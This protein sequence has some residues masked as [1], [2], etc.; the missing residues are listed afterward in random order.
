MPS[1]RL[2]VRRIAWT[3]CYGLLRQALGGREGGRFIYTIAGQLAPPSHGDS[4]RISSRAQRCNLLSLH[5]ATY[6]PGMSRLAAGSQAHPR[7]EI[8]RAQEPLTDSRTDCVTCSAVCKK[9]G[10]TGMEGLGRVAWG[11]PRGVLACPRFPP[12]HGVGPSMFLRDLFC[13]ICS[14][15]QNGR[16]NRSRSKNR[17]TSCTVIKI[18][19]NAPI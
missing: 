2:S 1:T 18:G 17:N 7:R 11:L 10:R 6:E 14:S 3:H 4:V 15:F 9:K 8:T 5:A 16:G 13:G 19:S 12:T